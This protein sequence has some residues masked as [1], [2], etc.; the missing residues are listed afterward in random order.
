MEIAADAQAEVIA[1]DAADPGEPITDHDWRRAVFHTRQDMV[2][3]VTL[4]AGLCEEA[5]NRKK[6]ARTTNI[7]LAV[8][9]A[10]L[11]VAVMRI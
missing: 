9:T 11:V 8:I 7:L 1:K 10:L 4:L 5:V 6:Q 2:L 3:V